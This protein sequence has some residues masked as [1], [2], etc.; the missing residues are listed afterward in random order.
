MV[1]LGSEMRAVTKR[2]A[3]FDMV[4][5]I[6]AGIILASMVIGVKIGHASLVMVVKGIHCSVIF[7][8]ALL[9]VKFVRVYVTAW[10]LPRLF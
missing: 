8:I 4:V 6:V 1:L 5:E 3:G 2:R 7:A 9:A 10:R